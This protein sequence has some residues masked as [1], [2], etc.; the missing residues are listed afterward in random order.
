MQVSK[1]FWGR[2]LYLVVLPML[3]AIAVICFVMRHE[4][5]P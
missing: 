4:L 3:A 5:F 2:L 1:H